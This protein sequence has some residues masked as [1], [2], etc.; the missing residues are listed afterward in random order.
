MRLTSEDIQDVLDHCGELDGRVIESHGDGFQALITSR[1][2]RRSAARVEAQV[3]FTD[4]R[5]SYVRE[6]TRWHE[7]LVDLLVSRGAQDPWGGAA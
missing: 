6:M 3:Y 7:H 2:P 4:G 5:I 1:F